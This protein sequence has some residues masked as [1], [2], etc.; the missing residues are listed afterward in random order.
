MYGFKNTLTG[1]MYGL[2]NRFLYRSKYVY[3]CRTF[4]FLFYSGRIFLLYHINVSRTV[5]SFYL[6]LAY[7]KF[8]VTM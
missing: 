3:N 2:K 7:L 5:V 4:Y 8:I 1:L 6:F